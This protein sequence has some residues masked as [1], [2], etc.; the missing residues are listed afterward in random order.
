MADTYTN[1]A[2]MAND[3]PGVFIAR[4]MIELLN[5]ILV[6]DKA[7]EPFA[8]ENS[9]SKTLRVVRVSR[10]SLP[11]APLIEGISPSTDNL[12]LE[13]VN[14]TV[15][16]WGLVVALT[17]V[18]ELTVVHPMLS[19]AIERV[20]MA[21]KET[22]EREDA[23][24]LM[25]APNVTF[26]GVIATRA[27]LAATDVFNTALAIAINAKLEMRGAP[28]YMNNGGYYIGFFQPPHKAAI[29]GSDQTFQLASNFAEQDR[30]KY[31]R[32]GE[33]MGVDWVMGTFLPVYVGVAAATTAAATATKAQYTVG[34]SGTLATANYQLKV[35]AREL[36]TDYERRLSV[37]TGNIAV[38]SPG[39]IAVVMPSSVNYSYDVYL[40]QAGG[41]IGYLVA[42][43]Q[44]AGSTYTIT[45]APAG[46]EAVAPESPALGINVYPGFVVGKGAFGTCT[47]NGMSLQT[48]TTPK[49]PSDSD[50]LAQRRK[51]GAKYMRKSFILDTGFIERF[52]TSSALAAAI[53]A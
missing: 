9:N 3:A 53:P 29:L 1:F 5:R 49:G 30:L 47:L 20:A 36:T 27:T 17:D 28:K 48:F 38:T 39:S 16:Q 15:E 2:L 31:G 13:N 10:V 12:T 18:L 44:A 8:L 46:T 50:P 19:I 32:V 43:R 4:K 52:E 45:T 37:Q 6:L 33:W 14:V 22:S 40:T 7:S 41:I 23:K 42:S 24:V 34:L 26:P 25:S 11:N 35:V 21:M 51:V